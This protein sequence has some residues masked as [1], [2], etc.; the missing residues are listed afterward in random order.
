LDPGPPSTETF[1]IQLFS[2]SAG[3]PGDLLFQT[4]TSDPSRAW[5]GQLINIAG[6]RKEYFYRLVLPQCFSVEANTTYWLEIAQLGDINSRFRWEN[7]NTLDGFAVQ[8]PIGT[9]WRLSSNPS[10]LAY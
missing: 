8:F 1:Q 5:T 9:P 3:L 6:A 4:T 10:Q 2:N 7:S